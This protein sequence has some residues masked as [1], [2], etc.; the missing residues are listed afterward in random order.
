MT[1]SQRNKKKPASA[2][3][4]HNARKRSRTPKKGLERLLI[5][6]GLVLLLAAS[7]VATLYFVFL[8]P[9]MRPGPADQQTATEV[10]PKPSATLPSRPPTTPSRPADKPDMQRMPRVAIVIDDMGYR[11][12]TGERLLHLDLNLTF[13]FLPDGPNSASQ[14]RE[15]RKLGRDVLLHLPLEP[16]DPTWDLGPGGLYVSMT[17]KKLQTTFT[18]NLAVVPMAMGINNHMGSLF[19]ENETAMRSLLEI[20][21]SKD[22]FFIDSITSSKSVGY[23]LARSMGVKTARRHIFLDNVHE[24][25]KVTSQ[26]MKLVAMAEKH[27]WAIG[28]AHPYPSTLAALREHADLFET[29]VR[30][31]GIS[32]LVR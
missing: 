31:V 16:N 27:N 11:K 23:D 29:R 30:L 6:T 3:K 9:T 15:A 13:S 4:T 7:M 32:E 8:R 21:R 5:L 17:K 2:R 26:L 1:T 14:A 20:I 25:K 24:N 19:T 22:L 28:L 10:R 12:D 18:K